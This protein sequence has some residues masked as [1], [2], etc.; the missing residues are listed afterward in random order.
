M[1]VIPD[2][3]AIGGLDDYINNVVPT[4]LG[5]SALFKLVTIPTVVGVTIPAL[6]DRVP[7][8]RPFDGFGRR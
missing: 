5:E 4:R 8:Y 7:V 6:F 1:N 2:G 3:N